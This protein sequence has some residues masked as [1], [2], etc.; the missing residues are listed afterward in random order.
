MVDLSEKQ[1]AECCIGIIDQRLTLTP[2]ESRLL[3]LI[4]NDIRL[5]FELD[6]AVQPLKLAGS[7]D[8]PTEWCW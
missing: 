3:Q 1:A 2:G 5:H 7:S 8:R 4:V 6:G